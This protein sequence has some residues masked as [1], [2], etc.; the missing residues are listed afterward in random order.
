MPDMAARLGYRYGTYNPF[1]NK[2]MEESF[3]I[4]MTNVYPEDPLIDSTTWS[5]I[6]NYVISNAPETI[7][8]DTLRSN[9]SKLLDRFK[10]ETIDI[11]T[12]NRAGVTSISYDDRSGS[13]MVGTAY[14]QSYSWPENPG[15]DYTFSSPIISQIGTDD[16]EYVTEVGYIHPSQ[17]PRGIVHRIQNE[18]IDTIFH[19]LYRPVATDF[20]DFENDGDLDILVCEFGNLMGQLSVLVDSA[21]S[22]SR[23]VLLNTPGTIKTEVSDMDGNGLKDIVVIASQGNEGIYILSQKSSGNFR[24]R[25]VIRFPPHYGSSW[26]DLVDYNNDG[27]MDIVVV[28]GDNADLSIFPKPYHGV[29][30]F[31]NDGNSNFEEVWFYPIY[32]STRVLGEDFDKDGDTD[33]AVISYFA[34]YDHVGNESFVY[35]ENIDPTNFG[36]QS[37]TLDNSDKGRWLVM[38]KGD[39]DSDGDIDILIGSFVLV[40]DNNYTMI[41]SWD[42]SKVDLVFLENTLINN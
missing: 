26:F 10:V 13:F 21:G 40:P 1:K 35:L 31:L 27:N 33:F 14:G 2:S 24:T 38:D 3:Y 4:R 9:R 42:S 8:V 30:L 17:V 39:P 18:D 11:D 20:I 12:V 37:Y 25:Q 32:G 15:N 28:N 5:E 41:E 7:P 16:V 6:H 19:K 22:F 29:R 23:K 34:E 36:F